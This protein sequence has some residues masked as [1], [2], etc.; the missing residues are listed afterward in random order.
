MQQPRISAKKFLGALAV[1]AVLY[2][3]LGAFLHYVVFPEQEPPEWAYSRAGFSFESPTGER[4]QL[5]RGPIETGGEFSEGHFDLRPGG[6]APRPHVHPHQE[7]R[8]EVLSG[9]LTALVGD[10]ERV[11]SAGET[12]VV[13]PGTPHQP[14]N[15][16]DVEMRSI[17]RITPAGKLGL[18][19]GQLSGL[20]S[21]PTFLQMMLFVQAYDIYP[22]TPPPA[23]MRVMSFLVAPTA[24][25]VGYRSFY[26]EHAKRFLESAAQQD[27]MRR[28]A[29]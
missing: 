29:S 5:I 12:L 2:F 9:S 4:F 16:G 23:V 25:L 8:F 1:A 22:A 11:V 28:P 10:E 13:P 27:G 26:P 14:F 17:A 15:R 20:D 3:G 21:K 24:R 6:H 7:E 19:F 18:F